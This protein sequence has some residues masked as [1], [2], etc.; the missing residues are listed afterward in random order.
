MAPPVRI[1]F[2]R[3][4]HSCVASN[5]SGEV[6]SC[7]VQYNKPLCLGLGEQDSCGACSPG[8]EVIVRLDDVSRIIG[9]LH[10]PKEGVRLQEVM[11]V[12]MPVHVVC[13]RLWLQPSTCFDTVVY[14]HRACT[15]V[16]EL[17][18]S[19]C[20]SSDESSASTIINH[21][22]CLALAGFVVLGKGGQQRGMLCRCCMHRTRAW[23]CKS[24]ASK[25]GGT[26]EHH[27][28]TT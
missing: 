3:L 7:S 6:F 12:T 13:S 27:Y 19:F 17:R 22:R 20:A 26:V 8:V 11:S 28:G 2:E 9:R 10:I 16:T 21:G 18:Q 1:L 23:Q 5:T 4:Q 25:Q 15:V 14:M 24:T